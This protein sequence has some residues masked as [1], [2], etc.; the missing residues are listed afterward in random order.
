MEPIFGNDILYEKVSCLY[1]TI[2]KRYFKE[3]RILLEHGLVIT[4]IEDLELTNCELNDLARII[5]IVNDSRI[6]YYH[7][8]F[9]NILIEIMNLMSNEEQEFILNKLEENVKEYLNKTK[10]IC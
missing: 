6:K 9:I 2:K 1:K 8:Y 5:E 10:I 4:D 7:F 3:I